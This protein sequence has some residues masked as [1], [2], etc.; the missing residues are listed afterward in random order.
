ME[1]IEVEFR[2]TI[3]PLVVILDLL[4]ANVLH[5]HTPTH[6]VLSSALLASSVEARR[7]IAELPLIIVT[8]EDMRHASFELLEGRMNM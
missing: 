5:A 6:T 3:Q 4:E 7:S 8:D 2:E 1:V